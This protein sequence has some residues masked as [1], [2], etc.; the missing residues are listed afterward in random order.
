MMFDCVVLLQF[1]V[2]ASVVVLQVTTS[3]APVIAP[4]MVTFPL[5]KIRPVVR[6]LSVIGL[7]QLLVLVEALSTTGVPDVPLHATFVVE[8]ETVR[9][10]VTFPGERDEGDVPPVM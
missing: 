10:S 7:V 1:P 4:L 5:T 8:P 2:A 9:A 3:S 6:L